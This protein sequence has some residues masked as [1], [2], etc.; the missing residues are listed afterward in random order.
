MGV[1]AL[2]ER[3]VFFFEKKKQKTFDLWCGA[4]RQRAPRNKS[5]L[6][7]F[8]KKEHSSF[9]YLNLTEP[10]PIGK[11]PKGRLCVVSEAPCRAS[12]GREYLLDA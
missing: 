4:H 11:H 2:E 7:L 1:S 6:V 9:L 3:K 5:F 10:K 12:D 8:F